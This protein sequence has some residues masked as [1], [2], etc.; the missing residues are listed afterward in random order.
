MTTL[1]DVAVAPSDAPNVP[2]ARV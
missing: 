1:R 2:R